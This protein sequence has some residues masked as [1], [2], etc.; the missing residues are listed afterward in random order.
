MPSAPTR[1]PAAV[2]GETGRP[3]QPRPCAQ[4][5]TEVSVPTTCQTQEPAGE[6]MPPSAW[7]ARPHFGARLGL[8]VRQRRR[9]GAASARHPRRIG[10]AQRVEAGA[11]NS[12]RKSSPPGTSGR[13]RAPAQ[14]QRQRVEA[15]IGPR[16]P[17]GLVGDGVV[18]RSIAPWRARSAVGPVSSR[19]G[20]VP[21]L[22]MRAAGHSSPRPSPGAPGRCGRRG[23]AARRRVSRAPRALARLARGPARRAAPRR[24]RASRSNR[25]DDGGRPRAIPGAPGIARDGARNRTEPADRRGAAKRC[26]VVGG[27]NEG[28]ARLAAAERPAARCMFLIC[29][30]QCRHRRGKGMVPWRRSWLGGAPY[31]HHYGKYVRMSMEKTYGAFH[32]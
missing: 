10:H 8:A 7:S 19:G 22:A 6:A 27:E 31:T 25:P 28:A 1:I 9:G 2:S 21:R 12:A 13:D 15:A 24:R 18:E 5:L 29:S 4:S 3:P 26:P 11:R 20:G 30:R 23:R 17:A 16:R 14:H 32:A